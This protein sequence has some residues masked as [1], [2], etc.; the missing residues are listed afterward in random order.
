LG[1]IHLFGGWRRQ[2]VRAFERRN[3]LK[4]H[5]CSKFYIKNAAAQ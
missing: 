4:K 2:K 3:A 5:D 1:Q